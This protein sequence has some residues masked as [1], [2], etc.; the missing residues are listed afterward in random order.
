MKLDES[1]FRNLVDH[2]YDGVYVVG[3]NRD[4]TYWNQGAERITGYKAGDVTGRCCRDNT[5]CPG[6]GVHSDILQ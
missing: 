2:L 1:F 6:C 4:I 3:K 5:D